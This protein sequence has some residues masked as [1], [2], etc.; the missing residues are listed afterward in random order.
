MAIVLLEYEEEVRLASKIIAK[1]NGINID[2]YS[3]YDTY[4]IYRQENDFIISSDIQDCEKYQL[5]F[6]SKPYTSVEL[7][8][9][10]SEGIKFGNK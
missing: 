7:L 2:V 3:D 10:L 5:C 1:M 9:K 6:L 4:S 8:S